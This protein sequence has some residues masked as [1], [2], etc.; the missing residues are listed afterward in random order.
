M[1]GAGHD[2]DEAG[3]APDLDALHEEFQ[4]KRAAATQAIVRSHASR[5][6]IVAGP[7]TGKTFTFR[8]ALNACEG[9][10]LALTFIRNLVDDLR[11]A[12]S[13][14]AE[15]FTFHA[16]CKYQLHRNPIDDLRP[17]W[18]YYPLLWSS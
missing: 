2:M 17:G 5:K 7:G 16:F 6:L 1:E 14:I 4:R 9:R 13:E 12:L 3:P 11:D 10:G 8:E 18:R 15:V